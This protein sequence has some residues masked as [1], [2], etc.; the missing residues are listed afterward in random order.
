[1]TTSNEYNVLAI[2]LSACMQFVFG[3]SVK[4]GLDSGLD[5]MDWTGLDSTGLSLIKTTLPNSYVQTA[6][7]TKAIMGHP[8]GGLSV[9]CFLVC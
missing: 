3:V 4:P 8:L 2:V 7:I 6:N 1:M 5:Y 9:S